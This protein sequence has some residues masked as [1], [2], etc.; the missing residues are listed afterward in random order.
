MRGGRQPAYQ[1]L[2]NGLRIAHRE[3]LTELV[4][5]STAQQTFN[6]ACNPGLVSCF[7]WL[8]AVADRYETYK[9]HRLQFEFHTRL[10]ASSGG[11][12][13][14]AFDFD[15]AD[16]APLNNIQALSY[17]DSTGVAA[18][19]DAVLQVNLAEGDRFSAARYTRN[20]GVPTVSDIKTYDTG[21][22][23]V[24]IDGIAAGTIGFVEIVYEVDLFT[25]QLSG[26]VGGSVTA[27]Q[28]GGD[29]THLFVAP[30]IAASS[31]LPFTID[32][33]GQGFTLTDNWEGQVDLR[34]AGIGLAD[35]FHPVAI[36][37]TT[38][39]CTLESKEVN[40][41]ATHGVYLA[42][43]RG[44]AGDVFQFYTTATTVVGAIWDFASALFSS[45]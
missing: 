21:R 22:L 40:A 13:T 1:A 44:L 17:R 26:P 33:A 4:S 38:A 41:G 6:F 28:A 43:L 10:P 34:L 3:V 31:N 39:A 25:P 19:Q 5:A 9:F 2:P 20:S 32:P 7:P 30:T 35:T 29:S 23:W 14:L 36:G 45:L 24:L 11:F 16:G 8:C 27:S 37:S 18:W 42:K 15:S 12:V